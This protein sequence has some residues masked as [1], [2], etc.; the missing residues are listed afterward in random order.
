VIDPFSADCIL[1]HAHSHDHSHRSAKSSKAPSIQSTTLESVMPEVSPVAI[2]QSRPPAHHGGSY[3]SLY[4][5]PAATRAS[6]VQT[7]NNIARSSSPVPADRTHKSRNRPSLDLWSP[8]SVIATSPPYEHEEHQSRGAKHTAP[9]NAPHEQTSLLERPTGT[10]TS[11]ATSASRELSS[12]GPKGHDH[13]QAQGH[14][15][16]GSMNMRALVLHVLGDALGNVGV[17]ATGLTIW[18]T[19]WSFKYYCDPVIS[20]IITAIIF[21]SA[22]PLGELSASHRLMQS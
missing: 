12:P 10:Y 6:F 16:G 18:L 17:I 2:R 22:L 8:D 19:S 5:H 11:S 15:H 9:A 14:S 3:S 4:G 21:H 13:A 7:A 20:L 1:E